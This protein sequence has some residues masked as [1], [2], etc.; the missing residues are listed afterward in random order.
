MAN[1]VSSTLAPGGGGHRWWY[2]SGMVPE[3]GLVVKLFDSE[4]GWGWGWR[5]EGVEVWRCAHCSVGVP[6]TEE[7]PARE[8]V[9]VR[10]LVCY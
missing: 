4:M 10:A 5:W 8:S 6:G 3:V 2:W 9:E 7:L 1:Y